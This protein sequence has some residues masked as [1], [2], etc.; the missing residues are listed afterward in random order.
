MKRPHTPQKIFCL[1]TGD[2]C[3]HFGNK[4][5]AKYL[6]HKVKEE[7]L[8]HQIEIIKMECTG[9]CKFAPVGFIQPDNEWFYDLHPK[10]LKHI[11]VTEIEK[12]V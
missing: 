4:E 8:K 5:L 1:C 10:E 6:R 9:R 3:K 2:K 11:F 7:G 12:E